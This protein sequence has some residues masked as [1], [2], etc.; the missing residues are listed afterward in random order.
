[1]PM[2]KAE[3]KLLDDLIDENRRQREIIREM[4]QERVANDK[5]WG[6]LIIKIVQKGSTA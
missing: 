4:I 2:T 3:E 6:E 1:M 5:Y